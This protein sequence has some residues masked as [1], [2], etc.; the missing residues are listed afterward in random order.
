MFDAMKIAKAIRQ[1]RIDQNMTQ[2]NLADAMGVSYQAVSNWERGNSMPDIAKLEQLC[3]VLHITVNEL[4]GMEEAAAAEP[5]PDVQE[6]KEAADEL[7][8]EKRFHLFDFLRK[9]RPGAL[10]EIVNAVYGEVKSF[11]FRKYGQTLHRFVSGDIS[12]VIDFQQGEARHGESHLL[13]VNVGIRVP[14]CEARSFDAELE[15]KKYYHEYECNIRSRLGEVEGKREFR[16]DLRKATEPILADIL[17]QIEEVVLPAF[18]ALNSRDGILL[19]RRE[20]SDFDTFNDHLILLEE[21]MIHGRRGER[22]KAAE[23]FRRHYRAMQEKP[24]HL[25]YLQKLAKEL[26]IEL[27]L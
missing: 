13:Y 9:P 5:V 14:E 18:D 26:E 12:Q 21:A 25:E 7:P 20:Y 17:W 15:Q 6:L 16:Y 27:D 19:H 24:N 22:D 10:D 4:L 11:G 8:A 23:L 2:K 3:G 1:A